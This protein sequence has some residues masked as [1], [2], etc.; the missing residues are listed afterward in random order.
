VSETYQAARG[1]TGV[2]TRM[3]GRARVTS[4]YLLSGD[5]PALVE[6]GPTT[7]SDALTTGLKG[8][9]LGPGDLAHVVLT[10]IH[11]DHA[12]GVGRLATKFPE[13]SIWVHERGAPH[14]ADPE[15]LVGSAARVYGE[16]RLRELF[17][18]VEPV[19]RERL[20]SVSDGDTISLGGRS[21][22]VL[23]TPGHASHHVA[24]V[25]S[26][27]GAVF[28]GDALGIHLPDVGVLR[29]ATPPPDIDLE[30]AVKSIE[31][32]RSRAETVLLFS[33][34]G[35]VSEVD[36]LCSL[37]ASRLRKWA[38]IVKGALE[39]T[40]DVDRIAALLE[41]ETA[42]EFDQVAG[43]DLDLD[44]YEI[45]SSMKIN[46]Q[47]LVRYW[48]KRAEREAPKPEGTQDR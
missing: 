32:I 23:Y 43:R 30:L 17:G 44:R 4:A 26:Q 37:A 39:E 25:D 8:L 27:S 20:R 3:A 46:A 33:H 38:G 1:I 48:K 13:A 18:P 11:L 28:T 6:T 7:S 24:L 40:D 15:K 22:E 35:P 34:F 21:L 5:E 29:P 16:E 10:H 9:G 19:P 42:S 2:D 12:G 31:R 45:L 36:E 14:L 41:R 47:G